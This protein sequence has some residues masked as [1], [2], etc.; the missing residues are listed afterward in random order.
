MTD[1][2]LPRHVHFCRHGDAFVF[3]DLKRDDYIL[4]H[5]ELAEAFDQV[6]ESKKNFRPAAP[7]EDL[8][9]PLTASGLLTI[10][11]QGGRPPKTVDVALAS[12][13]LFERQKEIASPPPRM[14]DYLAFFLACLRADWMLRRWAIADTTAHVSLRKQRRSTTID[15][16]ARQDT[17]TFLALRRLYPRPYLCLFDSLALVEFLAPRGAYPDWVFAVQL[18]PWA[19]H[20][21]VQQG[22]TVL[23]DGMEEI[24]DYT[25]IMS[26]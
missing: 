17:C 24:A 13:S 10:G 11:S 15:V 8:L 7:L 20:C 12:A 18:D 9:L 21:W 19:A 4:V 3:L 26:V 25:P 6:I 22:T 16:D 23:N 14:P 5:G 2:Q 1:F